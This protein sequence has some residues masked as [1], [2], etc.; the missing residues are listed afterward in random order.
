M[1]GRGAP[2]MAAHEISIHSNL[3]RTSSP[4][5]LAPHRPII[6]CTNCGLNQF[7]TKFGNCRKCGSKYSVELSATR[8][9]A[10]TLAYYSTPSRKLL[11]E[12]LRVRYTMKRIAQG[13]AECT[14]CGWHY[15]SPPHPPLPKYRRGEKLSVGVAIDALDSSYQT[16]YKW[17]KT[18]K[19]R[20]ASQRPNGVWEIP[21]SE[22]AKLQRERRKKEEKRSYFPRRCQNG[23]TGFLAA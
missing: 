16:F 8:W 18:G 22:I 15:I 6:R 7:A 12:R 17:L 20:G 23:C 4:T 21:A 3:S 11:S 2:Y 14:V 10:S 5:F 9:N 1:L 19:I 13:M